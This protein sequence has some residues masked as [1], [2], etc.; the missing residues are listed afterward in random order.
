MASG[1]SLAVDGSSPSSSVLYQRS[2]RLD[3]GEPIAFFEHAQIDS[4]EHL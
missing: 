2:D 3:F 4:M 1:N